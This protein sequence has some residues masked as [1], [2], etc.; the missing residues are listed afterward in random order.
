MKP[1]VGDF[2][3]VYGIMINYNDTKEMQNASLLQLNN[4][5]ILATDAEYILT[6]ITV[7]S[8]VTA[9]FTLSDK[10]TW[11]SDNAAIVINGTAAT[12]TR[13]SEDVNVVLTATVNGASKDF[14]VKVLKAEDA[15]LKLLA[16]FTMGED[17]EAS[18]STRDGSAVSDDKPYTEESG[19]YTLSIT[20]TNLNSAAYD[21]TGNRVLKVGTS[22]KS[23]SFTFTV[24]D[25]VSSVKIYIGRYNGN[26]AVSATVN[27]KQTQALDKNTANGE[28]DVLIIDTSTIKTITVSVNL[29]ARVNTI[30]YYG[31]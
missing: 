18:T 20:G 8:T 23:G 12:V 10:A 9:D 27:D 2:I 7:A 15:S 11:K 25:N 30:E 5:L 3:V 1:A 24:N 6:Q 17:G 22:K 16:S 28:Y 14:N 21:P 19:S 26:K 29:Y 31:A 4:K 13:G